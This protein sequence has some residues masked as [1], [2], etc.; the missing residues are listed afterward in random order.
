MEMTK[1]LFEVTKVVEYNDSGRHIGSYNYCHFSSDVIN[2]DAKEL[3]VF[4]GKTID[5]LTAHRDSIDRLRNIHINVLEDDLD[6]K[7]YQLIVNNHITNVYDLRKKLHRRYSGEII[8][9][10]AGVAKVK[11]EKI[12]KAMEE[13]GYMINLYTTERWN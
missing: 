2:M 10:V 3:S 12:I 7:L 8:S 9:N 11:G 13:K 1:D 5:C 4:I 6:P